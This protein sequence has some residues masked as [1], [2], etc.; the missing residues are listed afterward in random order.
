MKKGLGLYSSHTA[1][2]RIGRAGRMVAERRDPRMVSASGKTCAD[3]AQCGI[4]HRMEHHLP[5]HGPLRRTG[6]DLR[7]APAPESYDAMVRT[8]GIQRAVEHP[9]LR[10]PKPPAGNDRHR[11]ARHSRRR[12][13]CAER[14][15]PGRSGVALRSVPLLDTLRHLSQRR[16]PRGQRHGL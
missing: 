7:L 10:M 4:S 8:A 6:S 5:L 12:L 15:N 13:H 2:L 3:A 11:A 9:L 16:H 14:E 1:L